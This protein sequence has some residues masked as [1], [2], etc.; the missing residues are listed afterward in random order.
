MAIANL[1]NQRHQTK[2]AATI[3]FALI[4]VGCSEPDPAIINRLN[5]AEQAAA[6]CNNK[7]REVAELARSAKKII[8][9]LESA[10]SERAAACKSIWTATLINIIGYDCPPK[11]KY[12]TP[13]SYGLLANLALLSILIITLLIY[14]ALLIL[15]LALKIIQENRLRIVKS[16]ARKIIEDGK[17][18]AEEIIRSAMITKAA[19]EDQKNLAKTI[20]FEIKKQEKKL[21]QLNHEIEDRIAALAENANA[22]KLKNLID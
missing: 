1:K 15:G 13:A 22:E 6:E 21:A 4:F 5:H 10:Q 2:A 20:A 17:F 19:A 3:L 16:T 12:E 11:P 14:S 18:S 9:D 7:S 8:S